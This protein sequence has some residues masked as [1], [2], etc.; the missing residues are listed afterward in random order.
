MLLLRYLFSVFFKI[1]KAFRFLILC[2]FF[3]F[4][5]LVESSFCPQSFGIHNGEPWCGSVFIHWA[6]H[7]V[8]SIRNRMS[9]SFWKISWNISLIIPPHFSRFSISESPILPS[10]PPFSHYLA[11]WADPLIF[12]SLLCRLIFPYIFALLCLLSSILSSFP[13]IQFF[14]SAIMI[15]LPRAHF[16]SLRVPFYSILFLFNRSNMFSYP[17]EDIN[18]ILSFVLF[19]NFSPCT[20]CFHTLLFCSL[21]F[22]FCLPHQRHPPS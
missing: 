2:V 17:L 20:G 21:L 19:F 6:G 1:T 5:K 10:F 3:P 11:S 22:C 4:R 18:N 8:A 9:I 15:L 16:Y 7:L 13:S 12:L 14:I